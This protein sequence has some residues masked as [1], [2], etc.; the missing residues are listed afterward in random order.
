VICPIC[1]K[2]TKVIESRPVDAG[3]GVR[4]RRRCETCGHRF[5]TFERC[6][7][8]I[9]VVRKRDGSRQA[10]E[11]TKV[12][13]GLERAAHKRPEAEQVIEQITARVDEEARGAGEISTRRIGELC[14]AGLRE[15]DRIAYLRFATVHKQLADIE[16]ISAEL[17]DLAIA[18]NFDPEGLPA[19][20]SDSP[21]LVIEP[22]RREVHA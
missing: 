10:F 2:R 19:A 16:A 3:A 15:A 4:R 21:D 8:A 7:Q 20:G 5:T 14:L 1:D 17:S 6:A 13:A 9:A 12:R 22:A 18:G 11:A